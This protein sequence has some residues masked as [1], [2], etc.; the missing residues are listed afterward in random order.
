MNCL[1]LRKY[2]SEILQE[3][4]DIMWCV[5]VDDTKLRKAAVFLNINTSNPSGY[6][7]F[8]SGRYPNL[9]TGLLNI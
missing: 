5:Y 3:W 1:D 2:D 8:I 4:L 9:K 7:V 6:E